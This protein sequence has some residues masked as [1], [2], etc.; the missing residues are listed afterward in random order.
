[1]CIWPT[2]GAAASVH[3]NGGGG[4]AHAGGRVLSAPTV[5]EARVGLKFK[6][7]C[8]VKSLGKPAPKVVELA[9]ILCRIRSR[10]G[11]ECRIAFVGESFFSFRSSQGKSHGDPMVLSV[12]G[13]RVGAIH[14]QAA[15]RDGTQPS[16]YARR[17]REERSRRDVGCCAS[18]EGAI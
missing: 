17:F 5:T 4:I 8:S 10:F 2:I 14:I 1:M 18:C 6:P 13:N 16:T 7:I 3:A 12:D 9:A 11:V 15:P